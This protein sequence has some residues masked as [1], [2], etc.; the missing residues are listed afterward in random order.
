MHDVRSET[1]CAFVHQARTYQQLVCL[2][3]HQGHSRAMRERPAR[4]APDN[5]HLE[6]LYQWFVANPAVA[7]DR[8]LRYS[9]ALS[10]LPK[11]LRRGSSGG[12]WWQATNGDE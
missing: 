5:A 6:V 7:F 9:N 12:R 8:A 3:V 2:R 10:P 11:D 4:A 1:S